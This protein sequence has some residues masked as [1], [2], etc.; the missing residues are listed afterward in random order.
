MHSTDG[1]SI[2]LEILPSDYCLDRQ[3]PE[4]DQ[5][6]E[7]DLVDA[8]QPVSGGQGQWL[9]QRS[10]AQQQVGVYQQAVG[11][12]GHC[13]QQPFRST[14]IPLNSHC[15]QQPWNIASIYASK[16]AFRSALGTTW[17][18]SPPRRGAV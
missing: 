2:N 9:G 14:A 15:A 4:A 6:E 10:P 8:P 18:L 3:L 1:G 12:S 11:L 13:A 5:A 7:L 16:S 17:P